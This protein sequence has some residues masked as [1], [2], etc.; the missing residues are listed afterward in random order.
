MSITLEVGA[1]VVALHADL[2]WSDE[3]SWSP[4]EQSTE[5]TI[6]GALIV[7]SAARQAGRP[8]TLQPEDDSSAWMTRALVEQLRN[9]S[10]GVGQVMVLTLRGQVRNVVFRHHEPPALEANPVTHFADATDA[11][12]YRV[13]LRLTEI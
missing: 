7:S 1:T 12:P 13:T 2:L 11:D 10:E 5:R 8:I 4:V 9:W 6:T 3:F